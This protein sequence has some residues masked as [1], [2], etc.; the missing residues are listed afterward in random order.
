MQISVS[1]LQLFILARHNQK[2]IG[3]TLWCYLK[4]SL[5]NY[6]VKLSWQQPTKYDTPLITQNPP[7]TTPDK[8][9]S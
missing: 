8:I 9:I 1:M 6:W 2:E 3:T 4:V 5:Y 7:K